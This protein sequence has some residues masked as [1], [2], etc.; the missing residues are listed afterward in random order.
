LYIC[1]FNMTNSTGL[2]N[3]AAE[4]CRVEVWKNFNLSRHPKS[5]CEGNKRLSIN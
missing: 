2:Q 4:T 5:H 3:F 1:T